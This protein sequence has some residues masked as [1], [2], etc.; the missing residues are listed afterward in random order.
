MP[1]NSS[2][3]VLGRKIESVDDPVAL[4]HFR[5]VVIVPDSVEQTD[6]SDPDKARRWLY[7]YEGGEWTTEELWP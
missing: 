1:F 5:V 6:L 7:T 2:E 4:Q 3:L